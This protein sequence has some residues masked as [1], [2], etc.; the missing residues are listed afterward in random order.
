VPGSSAETA[1]AAAKARR[2]ILN[3]VDFSIGRV[4]KADCPG[5]STSPRLARAAWPGCGAAKN[6]YVFQL[7]KLSR[8]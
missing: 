5:R 2:E 4:I 1:S 6:A 7:V 8:Q 3:I